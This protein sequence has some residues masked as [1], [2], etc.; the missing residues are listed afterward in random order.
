MMKQITQS[1]EWL[2]KASLCLRTESFSDMP[3]REMHA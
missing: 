1:N 3:H 2:G